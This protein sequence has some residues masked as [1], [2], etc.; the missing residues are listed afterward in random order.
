MTLACSG[1]SPH[2]CAA[3]SSWLDVQNVLT[4]QGIPEPEQLRAW[5]ARLGL[6]QKLEQAIQDAGLAS[7]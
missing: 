5:A 7:T 6:Q 1:A 4:V 3:A 2:A